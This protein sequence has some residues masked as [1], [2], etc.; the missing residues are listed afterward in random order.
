MP[1]WPIMAPL[2]GGQSNAEEV[3]RGQRIERPHHL[4]GGAHQNDCFTSNGHGNCRGIRFPG[5]CLLCR[6]SNKGVGWSHLGT[7]DS[8]KEKQIWVI[9]E[10]RT[11]ARGSNRKRLR[12]LQRKNE[13]RK[14]KRKNKCSITLLVCPIFIPFEK[15]R[16]PIRSCRLMEA[17]SLTATVWTKFCTAHTIM[18]DSLC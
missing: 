13:N 15:G 10:K 18:R 11:K 3:R 17:K 12:L 8:N 2:I 6:T 14:K 1:D 7:P 5:G 16:P 9:R 4:S